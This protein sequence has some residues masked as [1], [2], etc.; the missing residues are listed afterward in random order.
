MTEL[1]KNFI[2]AVAVIATIMLAAAV[3]E[4]FR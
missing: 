3:Y 4:V 2:A 1:S